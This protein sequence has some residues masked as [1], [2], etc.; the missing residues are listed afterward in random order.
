ME[1]YLI[2]HGIAQERDIK[3]PEHER[4][5]TPEGRSKTQKVAKRLH[6]IGVRFDLILTS[7]SVRSRQTA[8][9]LLEG[10]LSTKLA[11]SN[12]L[13]PAGNIYNWLDWLQQWRQQPA[14]MAIVGHQ[15]NLGEWAS[16]LIWGEAKNTIVLKKA[17]IIGLS[18]PD[19]P[20]VGRSQMFWLTSPKLLL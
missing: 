13:A 12:H 17:G 11:E 7:P 20:P 8:D 5:L 14:V 16:I 9:I 2:R 1:L 18:L 4:L 6:Q 15:P 10:G 3:I 19:T